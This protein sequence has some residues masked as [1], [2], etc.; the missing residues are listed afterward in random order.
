[1]EPYDSK[2]NYKAIISRLRDDGDVGWIVEATGRHPKY[3]AGVTY[4]DQ[5]RCMAISYYKEREQLAVIIQGKM[6]EVRPAY[7]GDYYDTILVQMD[8]GG[9]VDRVSVITQGSLSYDMY[10]AKN[11]ALFVGDIIFFSG[12]SYGFETDR[13][14]LKKDTDAD[15]DA[16]IY[17]Y[18]FGEANS[19]LHLSEADEVLFSTQNIV[20]T[21]GADIR[22]RGL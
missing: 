6:S 9:T 2:V 22:R 3:D 12:W 5:D 21:S 4:N 8:S 7:K 20:F 15:Y 17:K 14:T 19:C 16:Y 10:T 18:K 13:Q 1:M 11:G